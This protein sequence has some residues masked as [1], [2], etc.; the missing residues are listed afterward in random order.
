MTASALGSGAFLSP[1]GDL[2][3]WSRPPRPSE[4]VSSLGTLH[5]RLA[6]AG[7]AVDTSADD[8]KQE[9]PQGMAD[10]PP[11]EEARTG[12]GAWQK[13]KKRVKK[14]VEGKRVEGKKLGTKKDLPIRESD[15]GEAGA[16]RKSKE[17]P[18]RD[19]DELEGFLARVDIGQGEELVP[20]LEQ[21]K[22]PRVG[23]RQLMQQLSV[24]QERLKAFLG[25]R[26]E[27]GDLLQRIPHAN[28][29]EI[30][31]LR[32][33]IEKKEEMLKR[34]LLEEDTDS[35]AS[36]ESDREEWKRVE[37]ERNKGLSNGN[38]HQNARDS[39][40]PARGQSAVKRAEKTGAGTVK[41]R[42]DIEDGEK[43]VHQKVKE[44]SEEKQSAMDAAALREKKQRMRRE[45]QEE[46]KRVKAS[47]ESIK[48]GR[49]QTGAS[50]ETPGKDGEKEKVSKDWTATGEKEPGKGMKEGRMVK[51]G[52]GGVEGR[53]N[54]QG[55]TGWRKTA[56]A[57]EGT[58]VVQEREAKQVLSSETKKKPP[59]E[60][61]QEEAPEMAKAKPDRSKDDGSSDQVQ[62]RLPSA[63]SSK[64]EKKK[65]KKRC[66]HVV[67]PKNAESDA[68][69]AQDRTGNTEQRASSGNFQR[70]KESVKKTTAEGLV[71]KTSAEGKEVPQSQQK[72][73][74]A[75]ARDALPEPQQQRI[76]QSAAAGKLV[77]EGQ[78]DKELVAL[79]ERAA[80]GDDDW[81]LCTKCG[82]WRML[83]YWLSAEQ[84]DPIDDWM[85]SDA[86]W[87]E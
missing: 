66:E 37:K 21:E 25:E 58:T 69:D 4:R 24:D 39:D 83:P 78:I 30:E 49:E 17:R 67:F 68:I 20:P 70:P 61:A 5:E 18:T 11:R 45:L 12:E 2:A 26:D 33:E 50:G 9:S 1:L 86:N 13:E 55:K 87:L 7:G 16:S 65:K 64:G 28:L 40:A 3:P 48:E 82:K 85:C 19:E 74:L 54:W 35:S 76:K 31:R 27:S 80:P 71:K 42:L 6:D 22:Q 32:K 81:V 15:E 46:L 36:S 8:G 29:K 62:E 56:L 44:R 47:Q 10:S 77:A 51:E 60:D 23:R 59:Q 57:R 72:A 34:K 73:A 63:T 43:E 79:G 14:R 41:G 53:A 52:K 75:A 84:F 38:V